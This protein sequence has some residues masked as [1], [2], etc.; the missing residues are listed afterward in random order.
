MNRI[1]GLL[2]LAFLLPN[3]AFVS[4]R[5]ESREA[6]D[7]SSGNNS[8]VN[9]EDSLTTIRIK[10]FEK[11]LS[12]QK[13]K[14]LY[15][16]LLPWFKNQEEQLDYL[17]LAKL[18]DKQEWA[19]EKRIWQRSKLPNDEMRQLMQSN[20]IAIGMPMD[21]VTKS[22]GEPKL[23]EVSGNPLFKNE[24]WRF[25]RSLST[26]EGFREEKRIVYFEGGKV[27]GWETD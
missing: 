14:E 25:V 8:P 19:N 10:D 6:Q 3:C 1:I 20:D 18:K 13:E 17:S 9:S 26:Q 4:N 12:S 15:S 7:Y 23:K 5:M 11:R 2:L 27:V 22:W 16:K 21:Y 24:K